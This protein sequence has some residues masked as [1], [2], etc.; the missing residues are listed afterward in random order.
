ML[1]FVVG[2]LVGMIIKNYEED[3]APSDSTETEDET[4]VKEEVTQTIKYDAKK[5]TSVGD[6]SCI[7]IEVK[8][9]WYV[10]DLLKLIE[11]FE[12]DKGLKVLSYVPETDVSGQIT[13]WLSHEPKKEVFFTGPN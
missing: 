13:L 10:S 8:E 6:R 12:K 11:E 2:V 4:E 3:S 1:W 5:A 9:D 7:F